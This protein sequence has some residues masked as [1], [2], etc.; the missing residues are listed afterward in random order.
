[1]HLADVSEPIY[2]SLPLSAE[3]GVHRN[4]THTTYDRHGIF[5]KNLLSVVL[6]RIGPGQI[7]VTGSTNVLRPRVMPEVWLFI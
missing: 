2:G 3:K 5:P 4:L 7:P 6:G 1:M